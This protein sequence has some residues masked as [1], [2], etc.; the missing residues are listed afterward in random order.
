[1]PVLTVNVA[2]LYQG[3][4][5]LTKRDDFEIWCL[6]SGGV[7]DGETVAQAAIRETQEETGLEIRLKALVGVYSRTGAVPDTHAV[8]FRAEPIG[9]TLRIQPGETIDVRYFPFDELPEDL[10][11]GHQKRIEDA[12]QGIGGSVA[13]RQEMI[14][15]S[16]KKPSQDELSAIRKRP[17]LERIQ[18][19]QK[20]LKQVKM[21]VETEVGSETSD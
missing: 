11:F 3:Q 6:P 15:P 13:V 20:A 16:G 12:I 10:T 9:G 8:L 17:R 19:F 21:R 4:I 1:M 7:E 14:M 18:F 5:L 2:V